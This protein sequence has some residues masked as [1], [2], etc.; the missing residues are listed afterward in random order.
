MNW[1]T[2]EAK[3]AIRLITRA[4]DCGSSHAANVAILQSLKAGFLKNISLMACCRFIEEAAEML[5]ARQD[6]CFGLHAVLNAEWDAVK[7]GPVLPASQVSTLVDENGMFMPSP[8]TFEIRK[9]DLDEIMLEIQAQLDR[10]RALGFRITYVDTHMFPEYHVPGMEESM[11]EWA[12][13]EGLLY[14]N[15][16]CS[17]LR[18]VKEKP[19]HLLDDIL[20][21]LV[22]ADEG[23]Y[24]Y[25]GHPAIDTQE[26]RSLGNQHISGEKLAAGRVLEAMLFTDPRI[27]ELCSKKGIVPIR[28]DEALQVTEKL[29]PLHEWFFT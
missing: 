23:Q 4:D 27:L 17:T 6:I 7:W 11:N 22:A 21:R 25:I 16:Y 5:A 18:R 13:K 19:D 14:W 26:M 28:Y 3:P 10:L 9:P 8:Q 20:S 12:D 1:E 2:S 15:R 24:L 29:P